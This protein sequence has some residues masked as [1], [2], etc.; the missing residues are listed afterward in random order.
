MHSN[1]P[2]NG[3]RC[4]D[5]GWPR[6]PCTSIHKICIQI[7][8]NPKVVNKVFGTVMSLENMKSSTG[9]IKM[10]NKKTS[11]VGME[12]GAASSHRK[13]SKMNLFFR[14][15]DEGNELHEVR[16]S[17]KPVK[18]SPKFLQ[19]LGTVTVKDNIM[20]VET[21]LYRTHSK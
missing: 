18:F 8:G 2:K 16:N 11:C 10:T 15:S 14:D 6:S 12:V 1:E 9:S 3:Q 4:L 5:S 7:Y 17:R 19:I 13:S 20:S 21:N